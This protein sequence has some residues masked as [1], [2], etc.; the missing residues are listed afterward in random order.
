MPTLILLLLKLYILILSWS[1]EFKLFTPLNILGYNKP[2]CLYNWSLLTFDPINGSINGFNVESKF[3]KL[4]KFGV[5]PITGVFK[6][7]DI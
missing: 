4:Y 1:L 3:G 7:I 2:S 6:N 5:D